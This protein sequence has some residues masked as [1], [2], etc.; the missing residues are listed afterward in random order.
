MGTTILASYRTKIIEVWMLY[1][2]KNLRIRLHFF[3]QGTL[4]L[5]FHPLAGFKMPNS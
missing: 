3:K 4:I 1:R 2:S 5:N